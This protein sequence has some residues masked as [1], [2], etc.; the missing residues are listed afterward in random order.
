MNLIAVDELVTGYNGDIWTSHDGGATWTDLTKGNA[1]LSQPWI[2]V[3][4][5]SSGTHVVAIGSGI[6]WT[7]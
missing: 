6:V 1:V 2:A 7:N 5:N 3:A 4:S